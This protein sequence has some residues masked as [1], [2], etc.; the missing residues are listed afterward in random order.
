MMWKEFE[1]IAGY[2]VSYETYSKIIE[3]MYMALPNEI[4]KYKFVKML[5]KKAFALPTPQS[6]LKEVKK[7]AKHLYEIC[8]RYSDYESREKM[9]KAAKAYAKRK[10][11]LD[12]VNDS[13]VY[14]FFNSG[15]EF[16]EIQRGCTYP[17][18]LVIGRGGHEYERI[19]L[20]K[21]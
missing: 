4:D 14:V 5:D 18:E 7:E 16:P 8:G 9:E 11:D 10:F 1:E 21:A 6:F 19:Q 15:Y 20:V 2:E 13:E 12:W 17:C 3:P